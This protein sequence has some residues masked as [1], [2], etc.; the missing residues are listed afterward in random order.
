MRAIATVF[1]HFL[2]EMLL[3]RLFLLDLQWH[4]LPFLQ[5]AFL[6]SRVLTKVSLSAC[7]DSLFAGPCVQIPGLQGA[8]H[9]PAG[10]S[11][12]RAE[13]LTLVVIALIRHRHHEQRGLLAFSNS[14]KLPWPF[15]HQATIVTTSSSGYS[16]LLI[17]QYEVSHR[18]LGG[19]NSFPQL[20]H[21]L[22]AQRWFNQPDSIA[23]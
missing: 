9:C 17:F 5:L 6:D 8:I 1:G 20:H 16:S 3:I 19:S 23:Q 10:F 22:F 21:L 18:F 11:S 4:W 2:S 14:P 12:L 13:G 7:W 15:I